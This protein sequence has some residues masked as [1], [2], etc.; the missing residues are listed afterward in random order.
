V[1]VSDSVEDEWIYIC[2]EGKCR[3]IKCLALNEDYTPDRQAL[4][5]SKDDL[6][7]M[8]NITE[9]KAELSKRKLKCKEEN[10]SESSVSQLAIDG[11]TVEHYM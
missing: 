11:V 9:A 5:E 10:E 3:I 7:M 6:P 1:V 4:N 8:A 2:M